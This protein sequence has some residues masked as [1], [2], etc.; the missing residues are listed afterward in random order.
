MTMGNAYESLGLYA[1]AEQF[2]QEAF[3][4]RM[5]KQGPA[6]LETRANGY[7][8]LTR[9]EDAREL[10]RE[11]IATGEKVWGLDHPTLGIAVHTLGEVELAAANYDRAVEHF[12]RAL[13][14][15]RKQPSTRFRPL[16]LYQL[17]QAS[18][19]LDDVDRAFSYLNESLNI[20]FK[21]EPPLSDDPHFTGL[22]R[23]PRFQKW[24]SSPR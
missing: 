4:L 7:R 3:A 12:Q 21:P 8:A 17:A 20:G 22:R 10:L 6:H 2:I 16:V 14:I 23:D 19:R 13:S 5:S 1:Q 11:T 24:Q 18:A 9:F 15:Y